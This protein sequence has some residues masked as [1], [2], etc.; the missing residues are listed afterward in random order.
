MVCYIWLIRLIV[1]EF[2]IIDANVQ[3][4]SNAKKCSA[5]LESVLLEDYQIPNIITLYTH[6]KYSSA[7]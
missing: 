2:K 7:R 4:D 1:R 6:L 3:N 5:Q